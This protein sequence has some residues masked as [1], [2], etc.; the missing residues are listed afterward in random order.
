M[1]VI[2]GIGGSLDRTSSALT[3]L[4]YTLAESVLA[5]CKTSLF[6][7]S[8]MNLPIF[9]PKLSIKRGGRVLAKFLDEVSS[10]DGFIF[11]SPEYHGSVSGLF[12]N[13]IDYLEFLADAE[14]PYLSG[15]PIGA[16]A[17]GG[18]EIS[19][20]ITLHNMVNII[21]SLRGI[22]VST[23]V[24]INLAHTRVVK[25]KIE[26]EAVKRRLSRLAHDI[27][28]LAAKLKD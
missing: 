21:H 11:A 10:A 13:T 25:G 8:K 19:A 12:K 28:T 1:T 4:K 17:T 22:S 14:P 5:G 3:V 15:K 18:G 2:V 20:S 27:S 9:N 16:I 7:V 23:N 24:A 6:D 26:S